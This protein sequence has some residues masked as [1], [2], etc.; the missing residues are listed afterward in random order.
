[1]RQ[2]WPV[3]LE[4]FDLK[5]VFVLLGNKNP[6]SAIMEYCAKKGIP[7]PLFLPTEEGAT[8]SRRFGCKV[9]TF[10]TYILVNLESLGR[11]GWS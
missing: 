10:V 1:M 7:P 8:N 11:F 2:C 6:V 9:T 3:S 4:Q 5:M